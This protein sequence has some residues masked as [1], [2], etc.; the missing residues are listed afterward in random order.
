MKKLKKLLILNF[1]LL[2]SCYLMGR[3]AVAQGVLTSQSILE[4]L[5]NMPPPGSEGESLTRGIKPKANPDAVTKVCDPI[6]NAALLSKTGKRGEQLTR[7]LYIE[8][9]PKVDLDIAFRRGDASLL[10]EGERQLNALGVALADKRLSSYSYVIAG[11]TDT[12]GGADYNDR[13]SCERALSA[14]KYLTLKFG[15]SEE[16]LIPMGFG[17][18]RL[19]DTNDKLSQANRRVEVRRYDGIPN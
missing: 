8:D 6:L 17:Y 15:I 4:S 19:K 3:E 9:V 12:E 2:L 5:M 13:L 1:S 18:S 14:R 7:T 11:H 10:A 16:R